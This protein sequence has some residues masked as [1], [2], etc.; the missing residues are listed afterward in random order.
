M[1]PSEPPLA[2]ASEVDRSKYRR[3]IERLEDDEVCAPSTIVN[4]F[5]AKGGFAKLRAEGRK[6][7]RIRMRHTFSR[8]C[9]NRKFPVLGDGMVLLPSQQPIRG[10]YGWRWKEAIKKPVQGART[11]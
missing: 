10:W 6:L 2:E 9:R 5:Q 3:V 11:K 8:L 4:S 7:W 1:C